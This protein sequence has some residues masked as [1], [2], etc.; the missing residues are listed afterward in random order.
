MVPII[1]FKDDEAMLAQANSLEFGLSAC[2]FTHDAARQRR[3]KDALHCGSVGVN[4]SLTHLPEVLLGGWKDS[5][6]RTEGGVEIL[7][8]YQKTKLVSAC[9]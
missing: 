2:V 7:E 4:H 3:L 6:F 1:P 9:D 5:G 8:P